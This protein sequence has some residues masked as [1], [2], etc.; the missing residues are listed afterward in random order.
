MLVLSRRKNESYKII[1]P[2]GDVIAITQVDIHARKSR[3]GIEAPKGYQMFRSL[4]F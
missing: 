4:H 2:N 3:V 1:S